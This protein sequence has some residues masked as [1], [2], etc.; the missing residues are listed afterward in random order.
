[1]RE[2]EKVRGPCNH[3]EDRKRN[4]TRNKIHSI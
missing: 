3:L 1:M 4:I 2:R